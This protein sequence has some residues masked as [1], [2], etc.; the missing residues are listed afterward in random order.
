MNQISAVTPVTDEADTFIQE[1]RKRLTT[2][3]YEVGTPM[4]ICNAWSDGVTCW[5]FQPSLYTFDN[6]PKTK[7]S[8]LH[9]CLS[10]ARAWLAN[11]RSGD[12]I[13]ESV[14]GFKP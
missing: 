6:L 2:L 14:L 12:E 11:L 4:L 1:A 5:T 3:G 9:E 10:N 8:T 13:I 7:G